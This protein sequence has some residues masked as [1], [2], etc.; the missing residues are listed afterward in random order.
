MYAP[1]YKY[2]SHTRLVL[3]SKAEMR[4]R[5]V[6]SP[7]EWDAVALTFAEPVAPRAFKR[8]IAYPPLGVA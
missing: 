3:E 7:D 6:S 1:T 4:G 5:D 8:Q 2:D